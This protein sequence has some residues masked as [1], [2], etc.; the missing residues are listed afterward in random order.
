[1]IVAKAINIKKS[2]LELAHILKYSSEN[3]VN[4]E[5]K[6]GEDFISIFCDKHFDIDGNHIRSK[7]LDVHL[8]AIDDLA[9]GALTLRYGFI[10]LNFYL[11]KVSTFISSHDSHPPGS[12]IY[13]IG[14]KQLL[15]F[16]GWRTKAED[17]ISQE[18]TN[19]GI[20][21]LTASMVRHL[22]V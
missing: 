19:C 7:I 18:L 22:E 12:I 2:A 4:E 11:N 5:Y 21:Y 3:L 1:M 17:D 6:A 10:G 8:S 13:K 16:K 14:I 20:Y 15:A 9:T